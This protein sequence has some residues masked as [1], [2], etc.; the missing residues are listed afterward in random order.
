MTK[1]CILKTGEPDV[2]WE[3]DPKEL[4]KKCKEHGISIHDA[5]FKENE[6]VG[7]FLLKRE[8]G[9]N[10]KKQSG[11]YTVKFNSMNE[12]DNFSVKTKEGFCNFHTHP[13]SCYLGEKCIIGCPSGEDIRETIRFMLY[14][15]VIHLI[16][17]IEGIYTIQVNPNYIDTLKDDK[18]SIK[19]RGCI[20]SLI[21]TYFKSTHGFRNVE[22]NLQ[23]SREERNPKSVC[24]PNDWVI[25]ANNFNLK[26]MISKSNKCTKNISCAGIPDYETIHAQNIPL[27]DYLKKYEIDCYSMTSSGVLRTIDFEPNEIMKILKNQINKFEKVHHKIKGWKPG[28]WFKAQFYENKFKGKKIMSE[29]KISVSFFQKMFQEIQKNKKLLSFPDE[30]I[31]FYF[32]DVVAPEKNETCTVEFTKHKKNKKKKKQ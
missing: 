8:F 25:F 12:G 32:K 18:I 23:K 2:L 13:L 14:G 21:E 17:T 20:V 3:I 31:K 10:C 22:Y 28:Q 5:L 24:K 26:N 9:R 19:E 7:D 29:N 4:N 15:N 1:H 6:Y 16:F 30:P 27:E 11:C